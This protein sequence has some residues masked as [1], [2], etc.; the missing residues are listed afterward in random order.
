MNAL[1]TLDLAWQ[2]VRDNRL[3]STLTTIGVIIGI[4]SVILLVTLGSSLQADLVAE[5]GGD[6]ARLITVTAAQAGPG[7]GAPFAMATQAVFTEYD[8]A[9]IGRLDGVGAVSTS[10]LG[11]PLALPYMW[12]ALA[13]VLGIAVG[14]LAGMYPAYRAARLDPIEALRHE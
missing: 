4:A 3:R 7:A 12:I 10:I 14:L 1:H 5:V 9:E 11:F 8:L 6:D 13:V 2:A